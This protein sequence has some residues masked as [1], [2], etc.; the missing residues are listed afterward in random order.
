MRD[1]PC[2]VFVTGVCGVGKSV[3]G[4]GLAGRLGAPFLEGDAFHPE[5]NIEK[6]RQ[7]IALVDA[8][9]WPW[10][11]RLGAAGGDA[12]RAT[13][14]AV[15]ACSALK[16]S[17]RQCLQTAANTRTVFLVLH[18]DPA[19]IEQRLAARVDHFMPPGLLPSQLATLEL[20]QTDES[21]I[22]VDITPSPDAIIEQL[23]RE[24]APQV[25]R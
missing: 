15:C 19:L 24:L 11:Q 21:A 25:A 17:Y 7:G 13:G 12:A 23:T 8:D 5:A 16:R 20:P 2:V 9:R 1:R 18:G 10:L 6:M 14:L 3:V 22:V 4:Q